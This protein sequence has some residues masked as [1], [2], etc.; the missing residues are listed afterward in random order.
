MLH[1]FAK[2][3]YLKIT[4]L[5]NCYAGNSVYVIMYLL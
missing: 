2:M 5:I 1:L 4:D 3:I